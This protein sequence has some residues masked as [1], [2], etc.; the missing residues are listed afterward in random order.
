[1][2]FRHPLRAPWS[3]VITFFV[4]IM[5]FAV[6]ASA[7]HAD[8]VVDAIA[9]GKALFTHPSF[10]GNGRACQSC[11]LGGGL[12]PG[13]LPDGKVLPSLGNAAAIFPRVNR[14]GALVTL[15]DQVHNCVAGAIEGT[16][17]AYDSPEMRSLV[18]YLTS[19]SQGKAI[20]MNGRPE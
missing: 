10:G 2:R 9:E 3:G 11:H 18:V 8:S 15:Q 14:H 4:S 12:E 17:P 1:M 19:L 13:R 5:L 6:M 7:A 16:P 20:D